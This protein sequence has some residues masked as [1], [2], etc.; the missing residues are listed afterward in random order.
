[1][2]NKVARSGAAVQLGFED[3]L[4]TQLAGPRGARQ[5]EDRSAVGESRQAAGLHRGGADIRKGEVAKQ[6]A[7]ALDVL[8]EQGRQ[9]L[10]RAVPPGKPGPPGGDDDLH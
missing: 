10:R 7:K 1:M 5:T 4:P 2:L 8:V 9:G 6:L 3:L